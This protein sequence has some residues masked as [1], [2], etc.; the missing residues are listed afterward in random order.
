M[1]VKA[2]PEASE[3]QQQG[4]LS[5]AEDTSSLATSDIQSVDT[6]GVGAYHEAAASRE[7][8]KG[9]AP[10]EAA[11]MTIKA[12]AVRQAPSNAPK[13]SQ[14]QPPKTAKL[15]VI[16]PRQDGSGAHP[17]SRLGPTASHPQSH[18]H[19]TIS[20]HLLPRQP[21][22][23]TPA[24]HGSTREIPGNGRADDVKE[25]DGRTDGSQA[26]GSH[27]ALQG[28]HAT[29]PHSLANLASSSRY[30][31]PGTQGSHVEPPGHH[32]QPI[33][34]A[35]SGPEQKAAPPAFHPYRN[36]WDDDRPLSFPKALAR[37]RT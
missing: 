37:K 11:G 4:S 20:H 14:W 17:S 5:L 13:P 12:A 29:R 33:V 27:Q 25:D 15:S 36:I 21:S 24:V 7:A 23:G 34:R 9:P 32:T 10:K 22:S 3:D 16:M 26:D 30:A 18:A 8:A 28:V 6:P 35:T 31:A 19:S 1:R 2:S